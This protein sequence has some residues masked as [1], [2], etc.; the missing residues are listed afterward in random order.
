MVRQ[1]AKKVVM[2]TSQIQSSETINRNKEREQIH[3]V[4]LP[5]M[6]KQGDCP[7]RNTNT[8]INS[9]SAENKKAQVICTVTKLGSKFNI[10]DVRNL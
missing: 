9:N 10:K 8:E 6:S 7:A 2:E 4:I 1:I 5:Y 3:L